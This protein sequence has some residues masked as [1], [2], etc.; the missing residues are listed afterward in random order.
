M[1]PGAAYAEVAP[2]LLIRTGE[3]SVDK[4]IIGVTISADENKDRTRELNLKEAY[5]TSIRRAGGEPV[6]F[7]MDTPV[8]KLS[9]VLSSMKGVLLSGGGDIDPE[10]FGGLPHP[11]VYGIDPARDAVEIA[12]AK[13]CARNK[14]PLLGICRGTQVIN[15][16]LGGTLYTDITDQL[17]GA[18]KHPCYPEKPRNYLAH[19][20]MI[21]I[22]THLTAITRQ[23]Q[24]KVNS[25][26]HQ[27]IKDLAPDLTLSAIAPDGLIEGVE[28]MFH[29]FF[30]GV[31]WH[32]EC[33]PESP[34]DQAIFS[35]FVRAANPED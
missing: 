18:L 11:K 24:M 21:K 12:L 14:Y 13:Y 2:I 8:D 7:P 4:P 1:Y 33:L 15:V 3:G 25:M 16:A 30:L 22:S 27:G 10:V 9:D 5:F 6:A 23:S 17:P 32:P 26:H 20:V 31:Q 34:S 28:L 29:P 35:A 19:S